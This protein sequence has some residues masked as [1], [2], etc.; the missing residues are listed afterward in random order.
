[1]ADILDKIVATKKEEVAAAKIITPEKELQK[2]AARR[3]FKRPFIESLRQ[4]HLS[5][6]IGIIAEIKRASPSK[7]IIRENLKAGQQARKYEQGGA[8][9]ISVLT[10]QDYFQ[11]SLADLEQA[12]KNSSLPVLR[13]DF[14]IDSYQFY[15]AA[16]SGA[17]AVLLIVRILSQTQL[18]DY[19]ALCRELDLDPLVEIH[20]EADLEQATLAGAELIGINNRNLATFKTD[21]AV[22]TRLVSQFGPGQIPVAASGISSAEDIH[23][24]KEAGINN[25]LIGESLVRASDPTRFLRQLLNNDQKN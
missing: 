1:M 15:E 21:L 6:S 11:G 5:G 10:D 16:A 22:A 2:E 12:R 25:F 4:T 17:D 14:L 9:A 24:T 20:D 7:G 8:T 13:K 3:D 19:L 18:S 23:R